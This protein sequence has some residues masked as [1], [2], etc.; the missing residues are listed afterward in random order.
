MHKIL[1]VVEEGESTW[2]LLKCSLVPRLSRGTWLVST[3]FSEVYSPL[4]RV[5]QHHQHTPSPYL[6]GVQRKIESNII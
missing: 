1:E 5:P 3:C 6:H 4:Y 2:K